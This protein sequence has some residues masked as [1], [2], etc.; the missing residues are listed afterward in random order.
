M[1]MKVYGQSGQGQKPVATNPR[2]EPI[3]SLLQGWLSECFLQDE[4]PKCDQY[5]G[6]SIFAQYLAIPSQICRLG[7][8]AILD[9]I[10][11]NTSTIYP[12]S[13]K[14]R[15]VS[16][17]L[18]VLPFVFETDL[19]TPT[20][21]PKLLMKWAYVSSSTPPQHDLFIGLQN[22]SKTMIGSTATT[23]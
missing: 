9:T 11:S 5:K 14:T 6:L 18:H 20:Q 19:G 4:S 15:T 12:S 7:T 10:R 13:V 1:R 17:A 8:P 21:K 23:G 16:T 3:R 22:L 2:L